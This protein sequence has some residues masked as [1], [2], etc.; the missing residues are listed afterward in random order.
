MLI[1]DSS[2]SA[3]KS[4]IQAGFSLLEAI[5][6]TGVTLCLMA[7]SAKFMFSALDN[8]QAASSARELGASVQL[9]RAKAT[10]KNN[11]Y[12]VAI[13][14]TA[15]AFAVQSCTAQDL[16]TTPP[17]CA[18][19][20]LD[21]PGAVIRLAKG[22]KFSTAGIVAPAPGDA[23]GPNQTTAM[24]FN[25]RG[26]LVDASNNPANNACFYVQRAGA[27][28]TAVCSTMVGKTTVYRLRGSTWEAQ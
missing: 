10:A 4:L 11:R 8:Y 18:G 19:W 6:I 28:P 25:S 20:A 1:R 14:A 12:R 23:S 15:G 16:S 13:D 21:A 17:G 2:P 5:V 7:M 26:L 9:A 27:Q 22:V 24:T 3:G